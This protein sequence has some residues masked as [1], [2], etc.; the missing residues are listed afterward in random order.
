MK[1]FMQWQR[2]FTRAPVPKVAK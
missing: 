2:V 1:H